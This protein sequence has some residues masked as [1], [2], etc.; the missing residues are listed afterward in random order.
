MVEEK[1]KKAEYIGSMRNGSVNANIMK[2]KY[3]YIF[4]VSKSYNKDGEWHD[5]SFFNEGDLIKLEELI[6]QIKEK[7]D[8]KAG[9]TGAV[10]RPYEKE[11]K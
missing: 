10:W 9:S 7:F 11:S 2:G 4:A 6:T 5:T 8:I 3:G 1:V